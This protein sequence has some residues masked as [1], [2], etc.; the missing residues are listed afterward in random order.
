MRPRT[1]LLVG[2]FCLSLFTALV[3]YI[4]LPY[5]SSFVGAAY[6]GFIIAGGALVAVVAF[7]SLPRLVSRHGARRVA[8]AFAVVEM[9]VFFVVA[10]FPG[11]F[12]AALL[13]AL[14]IALQ[15]LLSYE[16][17][18]LLEE[19]MHGEGTAGRVRTLF[20]T[21][22]NIAA[23]AAPLLI[24]AVL[25]DADAYG[26]VFLAAGASL[27]PFV[28]LFATGSLP[29]SR[30]I[31]TSHIPDTLA[32]IVRD[33]D[34]AAV[35]FGHFLL[36]TFLAW[37]SFYTPL[38]LHAILGIPWATLGWIFALML[39]PYALI[40]YPAGWIAD[41]V[42]GDKE[43]MF[44][45]FIIAG[46]ALASISLLSAS[47]S[48]ILIVCILIASR[49]GAALVESMTEGHFFRRVSEQDINSISVFRGVWPLAN[50]VALIIGSI[51]LLYGNYQLLFTLTGG[52]TAVAGVIAMLFIKDFR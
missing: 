24:A 2:N 48:I 18:L 8:L 43:L 47:S 37:A 44:A 31:E 15:P 49:V 41:R 26:R 23:L 52:F 39:L 51:I 5:L 27:V 38:F 35:T 33:R 6:A 40:E 20:T 4:L 3:G 13:A 28:V 9:L 7:P 11:A 19:T 50:L 17:D 14:A 1:V 32:C 42:L 45:G 10:L 21:A 34:L 12:A 29:Q 46:G 16:L 36:Y 22:W 25:A 30:P